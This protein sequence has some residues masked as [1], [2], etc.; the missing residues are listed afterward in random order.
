M[1]QDEWFARAGVARTGHTEIL[2]EL[3]G[4]QDVRMMMTVDDLR[5]VLATIHVPLSSVAKELD[6]RGIADTIDPL[7]GSYFIETLTDNKGGEI[8][9]YPRRIL[10]PDTYHSDISG[11]ADE[12]DL[13]FEKKYYLPEFPLPE[14]HSDEN[15]FLEH[16]PQIERAIFIATP[17]RGSDVA[18]SRVGEAL[19]RII[20]L[21][22]D[23]TTAVISLATLDP[24]FAEKLGIEGQMPQSTRRPSLRPR[25]SCSTAPRQSQTPKAFCST[26]P[27]KPPSGGSTCW[28]AASANWMPR[29]GPTCGVWP[30]GNTKRPAGWNASSAAWAAPLS[31][32]PTAKKAWRSSPKRKCTS[33]CWT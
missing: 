32:P 11:L 20:S 30:N 21:P 8:T 3:C 23:L 1:Q 33:C 13:V 5:V 18:V 28:P 7:A 15:A 14:E 2:G 4:V 12:V 25:R 27:T 26:M 29:I 19:S 10:H 9:L 31:G 24:L 16:L 17:H 6:T 22:K